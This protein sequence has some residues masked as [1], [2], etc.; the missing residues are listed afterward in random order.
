MRKK[1]RTDIQ[2]DYSIKLNNFQLLKKFRGIRFFNTPDFYE[3][4]TDFH[5]T[6]FVITF[7]GSEVKLTP[8][9]KSLTSKARYDTIDRD[10]L[11]RFVSYQL[12]N[13]GILE[14]LSRDDKTKIVVLKCSKQSLTSTD[15]HNDSNLF[16]ILKYYK[17][18]SVLGSEILF[19]D[20]RKH[21]I[22]K[23]M[24]HRGEY[25]LQEI[26][27]TQR[28][29]NAMYDSGLVPENV[30]LRGLYNSGDTLVINDMLVK[31]AVINPNENRV[32]D[33]L[34]ID[35]QDRVK[36][37]VCKLRIKTTAEHHLDRGI[38]SLFVYRN[39]ATEGVN[40]IDPATL[41]HDLSFFLD[42]VIIDVPE[43][44][45]NIEEYATFLNTM[46]S[47][48]NMES[49]QC[50]ISRDITILSR[51]KRKNKRKSKRKSKRKL[52]R[53]SRRKSRRKSILK[54]PLKYF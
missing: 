6:R 16:Q 17:D 28:Q 8:Y 30:L 24:N 46:A 2:P 51:G 23:D 33:I 53:K 32:D 26:A 37:Q 1:Q 41:S 54:R 20:Q 9:F 25:N 13:S 21:I 22:H 43:V 45:L 10:I 5:G 40:Y 34:E 31:H 15:F 50:A 19:E 14:Q 44:N 7:E 39:D 49:G 12:L 38:V 18:S 29:I 48:E 27:D 3:Y 52:N 35:I 36:V 4:M 47:A 11:H 42:S